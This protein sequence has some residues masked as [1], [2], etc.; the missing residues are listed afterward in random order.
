[1]RAWV[2][3]GLL[4]TVVAGV[5]APAAI[6]VSG[7]DTI[8]TIA[9]TGTAGF[10]GDGGQATSAQLNYPD[11]TCLRRAGERVHRGLPQQPH[12]E[13]EQRK[14]H[15]R[16]R[17]RH[18]RLCRRRRPGDLGAALHAR[19]AWRS[20]A[21]G[22]CTSPTT[23]NNRDPQDHAA[24]SS[25]RSPARAQRATPATAGRRRRPRSTLPRASPSTRRETSTSPTGQRSCPQGDAGGD[26]HHRRRNRHGGLLRRRRS[27]DIRAARPRRTAS[28]STRRATST[29][30]T[31]STTGCGR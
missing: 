3:I 22:T 2:R 9:G 23:D 29:S 17:H 27:G 13:A 26:H 30:P 4:A 25:R 15:D 14:H 20:T 19:S 10:S 28:R 5:V 6:G 1:M 11:G 24:G 31:Q 18:G 21:R 12:P 7:G 16:R 8:T